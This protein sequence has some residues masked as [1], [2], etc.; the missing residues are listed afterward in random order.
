MQRHNLNYFIEVS[1]KTGDGIKELVQ[2]I[3]KVLYH[4]NKDNLFEFKESETSS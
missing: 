4:G 2:H 1:A 3:G